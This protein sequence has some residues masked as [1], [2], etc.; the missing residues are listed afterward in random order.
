MQYSQQDLYRAIDFCNRNSIDTIVDVWIAEL[1]AQVRAETFDAA[2][3]EAAA[4]IPLEC[5]EPQDW[6]CLE[7]KAKWHGYWSEHIRKLTPASALKALA[8]RDAKIRQL[9]AEALA[10]PLNRCAK[11]RKILDLLDGDAIRALAPASARKALDLA[12]REA[13]RANSESD[14]REAR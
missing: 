13:E 12:A 8:E 1:I 4:H 3:E 6:E 2:Y 7:C 14:A 11:L 9:A 10:D 5:N